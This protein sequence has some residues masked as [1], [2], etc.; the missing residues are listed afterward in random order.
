MR[1][2]MDAGEVQEKLREQEDTKCRMHY[3]M[4]V[5]T[6]GQHLDALW[7]FT[8]DSEVFVVSLHVNSSSPCKV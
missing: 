7:I 6:C 8:A 3:K 5:L 2:E 4:L 1:R